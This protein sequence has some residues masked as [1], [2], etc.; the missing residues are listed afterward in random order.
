ML[1]A[2]EGVYRNGVVELLEKVNLPEEARVVV[3]LMPPLPGSVDLQARGITREQAADLRGQFEAFNEDWE[4]P[5][6]DVYDAL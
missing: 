4:R 5:E 6:M 1:T 3:T 2:V